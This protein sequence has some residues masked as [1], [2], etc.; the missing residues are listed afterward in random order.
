MQGGFNPNQGMPYIDPNQAYQMQQQQF[1]HNGQGMMGI[2]PGQQ[3]MM[4][5]QLPQGVYYMNNQMA[6]MGLGPQMNDPNANMMMH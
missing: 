3:Q 1:M 2:P 6:N 5:Q 4:Q